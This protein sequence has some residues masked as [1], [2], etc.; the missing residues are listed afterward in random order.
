MNDNLSFGNNYGDVIVMSVQA[1][2]IVLDGITSNH[3]T[4]AICYMSKD[5]WS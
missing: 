4:L 2:K 1:N 3:V 5:D